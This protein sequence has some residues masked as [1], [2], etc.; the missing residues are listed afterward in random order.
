MKTL[1]SKSEE[2]NMTEKTWKKGIEGES[3][4]EEYI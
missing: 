1:T 4:Y 2:G 3:S